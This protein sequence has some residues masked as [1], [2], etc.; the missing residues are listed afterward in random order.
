[1]K[2]KSR[3]LAIILV[4]LLMASTIIP[5]TLFASE[6]TLVEGATYS[7]KFNNVDAIRADGWKGYFSTDPQAGVPFTEM[8]ESDYTNQTYYE[9]W[10]GAVITRSQKQGKYNTF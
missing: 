1:M 2:N 7:S 3:I 10:G 4:V 8:T 9:T 6:N 5:Q